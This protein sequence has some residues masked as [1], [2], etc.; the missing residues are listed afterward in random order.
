MPQDPEHGR[1]TMTT[2]TS[3]IAAAL[4]IMTASTAASST[5]TAGTQL[6]VSVTVTRPVRMTTMHRSSPNDGAT[7]SMT[8]AQ[9]VEVSIDHGTV[10]RSP[11]GL[12]EVHGDPHRDSVLTITY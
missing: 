5:D 12:V 11:N 8:E 7:I 10:T 9:H 4:L 1:N 6:H 2:T 3:A